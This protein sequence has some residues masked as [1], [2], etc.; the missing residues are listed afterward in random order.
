MYE[1]MKALLTSGSAFA[2]SMATLFSPMG[3]EYGLAQKHPHSEIT[4]N[5]IATYQTLMEELR[6][7]SL[8]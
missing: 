7:E 6:G 3:A 5:N 1:L 8:F 2:G 4:L